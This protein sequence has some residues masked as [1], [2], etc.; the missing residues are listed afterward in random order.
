MTGTGS[1]GGR[2][3]TVAA[4]WP[5]GSKGRSPGREAVLSREHVLDAAMEILITEGMPRLTVRGLATKLGVA[6]TAIYWHVGDKQ[7][8]VDGLVDK[9]IEQFSAVSVVVRGRSH[10]ARL[11]SLGR[12]LRRSLLEQADLVTVVHRQGRIAALF[13]PARRALVGELVGAGL[14]GPAVAVAAQAI[15]NLVVG[16]VLLDRQV[17][18]QPAQQEGFG[19]LWASED[20]PG[21]PEL[22]AHL[23]R[24]VSDEAMFS[25]SLR[26][27]VR[28]ALDGR[29]VSP[30]EPAAGRS[31]GPGRPHR[32]K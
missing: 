12:S 32:S 24:P 18:R 30:A 29:T 10:E 5:D 26:A 21:G 8:L 20:L 28:A 1:Q 27:L 2:R 9:I 4:S 3:R 14:D 15:L 16:S 23:T 7:A 6:V 31:S 17:E 13:Q 25:Y 11:M 19:D 22:L